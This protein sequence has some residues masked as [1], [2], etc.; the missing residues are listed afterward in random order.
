SRRRAWD[1]RHEPTIPRY[2]RPE[3]KGSVDELALRWRSMPDASGTI[4]LADALRN[5]PRAS[6]VDELGTS[7]A[8][9]FANDA[10]VLTAVARMYMAAQRLGDAQ[11]ALISAGKAAPRE[12]DVY[13]WLGEVLL[14]RGDADRAVKVL[15]RAMQLGAKD[16]E[17]RLWMERAKVFRTMQAT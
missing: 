9:R 3:M 6:L 10:A 7:A 14:R 11:T 17:T 8:Q 4:A 15:E 16:A 5:A 2:L 12:P 13:R 1:P